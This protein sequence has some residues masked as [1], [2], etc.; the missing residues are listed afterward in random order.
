MFRPRLLQ[1]SMNASLVR[2]NN[3]Q[4]LENPKLDHSS[5]MDVISA[6]IV[7]KGGKQHTEAAE[8]P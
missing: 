8:N 1:D 7:L 4:D 2:V 5:Y 3:V 6:G